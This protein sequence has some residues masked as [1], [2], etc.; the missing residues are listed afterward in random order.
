MSRRFVSLVVLGVLGSL[1]AAIPNAGAVPQEAAPA[2]IRLDAKTFNPA[3]GAP[4]LAPGLT[5]AGYARNQAGYYIVQADGPIDPGWK[6]GVVAEGAELLDYI[7]DF[8]FKARMNP[9][10]AARVERL[11]GVA[12]VG[13]F[14]PAYKLPADIDASGAGLYRVRIERG[15]DAAG[16]AAELAAT[17]AT[18]IG[19]NG[20]YVTVGVAAGQLEAVAG[21]LDVAWVERYVPAEK[22][23]EY[24]AGVVI[25]ANTANAN[26]YDGSTQVVAVSDTGIGDGTQSGAHP[27]IPASRIVSI[28]NW[29][30]ATNTCF[31]SITDDGAQD[32]DSG[33][34]T[35]TAGSVLSD[36][37][38]AGEGKGA[39]PAASLVFQAT[40]N[41]ADISN[42]C[43]VFGG[44]PANG[45]FL[46]GLPDDLRDMYQQAY[47]DGA[48]V[49]SNSWGAALAGDY[50]LD[51]ANTDDFIWDNP[52]MTIT[53]SAGN[54]GSDSDSNGVVD[55]DSIGS[56]A[57]AKNVIT[58]GASEG[59]RQGHYECD[60]GLSYPSSD[61][62]QSGQT[63]SSM[64]G[65]QVG[66]LG[67]ATRWGFNTPPLSTDATAGNSEQMAAFSSRG[68][69]DDG[70]IKPDVVAPGTWV[71]SGFSS[72][73]QQG[74]GDPTNPQ[75]GAYQWDGWGMPLNDQYKYMGG[76]SMSNPI[77]AG[78]AAV[79]RDYYEK[80]HS[81]D[82]SAALVKATLINSAV[83]MADENNDGVDDNDYPIPNVHEGWGRID[84]VAA[85]DGG[86]EFDDASFVSTGGTV[87]S[88]FS[89]E[90]A[91]APFKVSLVWS[92]FPSTEA[93]AVNLVN[94]LDLVVTAPGGTQ[95]R[96][97]V[98]S[99]G[100]SQTGRSAD[101]LNNVEN[102]YVQS[103]PAGTWTV[104]VAGFNVPNGPQPFAVVVDGNL[105]TVN[106]P[107][108][109]TIET[110]SDG[111][112]VSGTVPISINAT[113]EDA[114]GTLNVQW[115]VDGGS[116][117][118]A[119]WNVGTGRY[120]A[121]WDSTADTDGGHTINARATDSGSAVG[122][123][124][125][126]VA[127]D[128]IPAAL[129]HVGDLDGSRTSAKGGKW[130]P[131]VAVTIHAQGETPVAGATVTG[132]W[133]NGTTGSASCVTD[134]SGTCSVT[135][136]NVARNT[137]SVTLTVT[138]V[139]HPSYDYAAGAN[140]DPDTDS[141]GTTIVVPKDGPPPPPSGDTVHVSD[142]DASSSPNGSRWTA[143]V[144]VRVHDGNEVVVAGATV[145]G[146]WSEGAKG[147][148]S[149][150]T[151]ASG[152]CSVQK[153]I[154]GNT[155]NATFTVTS[156][157]TAAGDTYDASSN[158]DP[159][160]DSDGTS[161]V[162]T[163]P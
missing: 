2:A 161:I 116:W 146:T 89:V 101:R 59:D 41:Y 38:P 64:G 12:W 13:V 63:C 39:A 112:T 87:V 123:D 137:I 99:G 69:T 4:D 128:N 111:A 1:F 114:A 78:G 104:E 152:M 118:T 17:G 144:T 145:N 66:Y 163:A 108:S 103:A 100:W 106:Q 96:G 159:D 25:G 65:N 43:Q 84:L 72:L 80:A 73:Y 15:A 81:H 138:N 97:N 20:G 90:S 24:G 102:V 74:Y 126:G 129:M 42:F 18:V 68:P 140:H 47:N 55:N 143:T 109:V 10:Q 49:H 117:Q 29:P 83:D 132:A 151:D 19:R 32:V 62:Y 154:K 61:G 5:I 52:N 153:G 27:D 94:D 91:G 14:Q 76:T 54:D 31:Q 58:V 79:V 77:A 22:H 110:P 26:G 30:G 150:T 60:T 139:T 37:G 67:T 136:S 46:T 160:G 135:K 130:N 125:V 122:S 119:T 85:T 131:S 34:G 92:D 44:W 120:E 133:S 121:S 9:A 147:S 8:A 134:A 98:F 21:V 35:H 142:L 75:N 33:H 105:G 16:A 127:V 40:E 71:L 124:A 93:A 56:P 50:T 28:H 115:N 149:C 95:Y 162:V 156:V 51:S 53:F 148:G 82:A 57:T 86:A 36:G 157:T 11:E 6:A 88:N 70:R 113:D 45:Y 48:R 23:N 107:P 158:H 7:P 141:D 3:D 155:S